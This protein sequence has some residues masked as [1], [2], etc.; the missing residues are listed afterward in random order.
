MHAARLDAISTPSGHTYELHACGH[1]VLELE[2]ER[3]IHAERRGEVYRAG[4][5][6]A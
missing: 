6:G 2:E 3:Q 4:T 1:C 5:L